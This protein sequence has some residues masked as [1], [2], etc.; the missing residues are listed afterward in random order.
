MPEE[1]LGSS[2]IPIIDPEDMYTSVY[3]AVHV[4]LASYI[5]V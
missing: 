3:I 4:C 1:E 5:H 2:C